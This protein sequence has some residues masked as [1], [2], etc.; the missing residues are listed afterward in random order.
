LPPTRQ[1]PRQARNDKW[2]TTDH[3]SEQRL[4][5]QLGHI[6]PQGQIG[7][8]PGALREYVQAL[9]EMGFDFIGV[10]DHVLA[11]DPSR[12]EASGH[13]RP[14][15]DEMYREPF[16][17]LSFIAGCTKRLGLATSILLVPQRPTAL[18]AKQA[19]ELDLLSGGRLRLGV[20]L[21]MI[22]LEYEALGQDFHTRGKRLEEQ[23]ELLRLLWTRDSVDF[24]GRW[25]SVR[26][27]AIRPL[28]VQRPIPVWMG[29]GVG[30]RGV[31]EPALRRVA[32]LADGWCPLPGTPED[33]DQAWGILQD[34]LRAAGR[35]PSAFGYEMRTVSYKGTPDEWVV[36]Y[37]R[38]K[39]RGAT[40]YAVDNRG[41]HV[42]GIEK[43]LASLG[44]WIEAV[45]KA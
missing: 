38:Q 21:G 13:A 31:T 8:D 45:R 25:D 28:P 27:A 32:R 9:E 6:F 43:H 26:H 14:R 10:A 7:F 42:H 18:V 23:V 24:E 12:W 4:P 3:D 22:P 41:A 29:G 11:A 2:G 33:E 16:A 37:K 44:S 20:G 30:H 15:D 17:L 34:S 19:A 39:A 1:I 36:G 40:H 35:D 5:M